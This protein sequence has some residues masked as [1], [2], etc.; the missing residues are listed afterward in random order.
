MVQSDNIDDTIQNLTQSINN[1]TLKI[2]DVET[3][4]K[5]QQEQINIPKVNRERKI[6]QRE[7]LVDINRATIRDRCGHT[8]RV[9][10]TVEIVNN[11]TSFSEW[12]SVK[13]LSNSIKHKR[14]IAWRPCDVDKFGIIYDTERTT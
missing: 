6:A 14:K 3:E 2:E 4:L 1:I 11:Y 5:L 13:I 10:D 12:R 8:I 9:E 7:A